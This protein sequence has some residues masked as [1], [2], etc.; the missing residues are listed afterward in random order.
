MNG[1]KL[2]LEL[3]RKM[4]LV[5]M[6]EEKIR[7]YYPADEMKT[8]AHLYIGGEAIAA[9]VCQALRTND[10]IFG[11]YR[12]HG[13]FLSR[14]GDTDGFFAEMYGKKTGI[15]KGKAGSMHLTAPEYGLMGTSAVV[16]TTIPVA[17][18]CAF[19]L[20]YQH[21]KGIAAVFFGDGA[22]DEGVFW[23]SLNF[24]CLKK[25]PVLF[26][27][28]DNGLAIH[29]KTE[30]RH[31][32]RSISNI[33][34]QFDC[35]VLQSATTEAE[36]IYKLTLQAISLYRKNNKPVFLWFKY[37]RYLEHV[38]IN[39]DFQFGYRSEEEFKKW[40]KVDPIKIQRK[41]LENL[42]Y[43]E[44]VLKKIEKTIVDKIEKSIISAH[45]ARFSADE[46]LYKDV[47]V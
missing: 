10:K 2:N 41:K 20:K 27:C 15:A 4:F 24:A 9:G 46:E 11:S 28:E 25:L 45:V 22:V 32:Y 35:S 47:Y 36:V 14:T 33:V 43:A 34:K 13:I 7:K 23:E 5:R 44:D 3:Y 30:E 1:K 17:L 29:A 21:K 40:Y 16:G 26:I 8:P 6:S 42:G 37:Y 12:N 18:G 19:S 39:A 31:G 38:G